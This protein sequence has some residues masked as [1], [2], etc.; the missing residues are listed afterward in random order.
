[1]PEPEICV[2]HQEGLLLGEGCWLGVRV[3]LG[4]CWRQRERARGPLQGS[5]GC[6]G[7]ASP[8]GGGQHQIP[9]GGAQ[10][11]EHRGQE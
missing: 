10:R 1:M 2:R 4:L 3:C 8:G 5:G 6:G 9:E 11:E 7:L